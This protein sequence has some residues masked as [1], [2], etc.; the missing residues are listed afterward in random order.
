MG[1]RSDKRV[2]SLVSEG[3]V[4]V[5]LD[6]SEV[7]LPP[8][9]LMP[10]LPDVKAK[11]LLQALRKVSYWASNQKS[12]DHFGRFQE[13]ELSPFTAP[14]DHLD[15]S[16]SDISQL[17]RRHDELIEKW[18]EL[19]ALF[20]SFATRYVLLIFVDYQLLSDHDTLTIVQN[21]VLYSYMPR[22]SLE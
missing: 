12:R 13:G 9:E 19:Q 11:K 20:S 2:E 17:A 16:D 5:D 21:L 8:N 7:L 10:S 3:I 14:F 6:R 15:R 18:S 4:V 22:G 1:V